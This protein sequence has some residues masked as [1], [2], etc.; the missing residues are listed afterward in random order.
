L[1]DFLY[2]SDIMPLPSNNLKRSR[3]PLLR[4][5]SESGW[6]W[7]GTWWTT[8]A[9]ACSFSFCGKFYPYGA[10]NAPASG[11]RFNPGYCYHPGL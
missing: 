5:G 7:T 8:G 4:M 2:F 10:R 1:P 3:S 6:R 11:S 9:S